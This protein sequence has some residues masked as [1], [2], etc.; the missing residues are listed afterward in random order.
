[1]TY[2]GGEDKTDAYRS[3]SGYDYAR[4]NGIRF[5]TPVLAAATGSAIF[6][7]K[8][9]SKG[10]GNII[11]ID[12]KNGYQ[13]WY[14]HLDDNDLIV[15]TEGTE[16]LVQKGQQVGKVGMTGNTNGPHIHFSVFKDGN[17]NGTFTDDYPYGLV[18]PLGWDGDY[19]DPWTE[20][21]NGNTHG[22]TSYNLF[23]ARLKP[24]I[25]S[26]PTS[27]AT[28]YMD[29]VQVDVPG[30]A[31]PVFVTI[32]SKYGPF[33][34][35]QGN[36]ESIMPS[37]FLTALDNL[38]NKITQFFQKIKISYDY[39][40]A[41]LYGIEEDSIRLNH[42]NEKSKAWEPLPTTL[43]KTNKIAV[44]Y[45]SHF[46]QFALMGEITDKISPTTEVVIDGDK[47]EQGWYKSSL[48]VTLLGKDNE[49]GVGVSET[50]YTT[51]GED[52]LEY[53]KALNFEEEGEYVITYK[54]IDNLYNVENQKTVTFH[55]DKTVPEAI[56]KYDLGRQEIVIVG[57][58]ASLAFFTEK[59]TGKNKQEIIISDKAGNTANFSVKDKE[60]GKNARITIDSMQ[61]NDN[62]PI[63]LGDNKFSVQYVVSASAVKAFNQT[64][65]VG[66][67]VKVKTKYSSDNNITEISTLDSN[68]IIQKEDMPGMKLL[69]LQTEN[70]TVNYSY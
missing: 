60:K 54:S 21:A 57:K 3:H 27:G 33:E 43:D 63:Y 48:S 65:Q 70:G 4:R 37:I 9:N 30:G 6:I 47:G 31:S 29:K 24:V 32:S 56:I 39:S 2:V 69:L 59:N 36:L 12:H 67:E 8:A 7:H 22:A 25:Q 51:N 62:S 35:S 58:D 40:D 50:L 68:G 18:D 66:E 16:V 42:Y 14:E 20:Y 49:G 1:M 23:T 28:L 44:A 13:T 55:I 38:N 10:A 34:S 41:E 52:W 15:K 45:T 46:S 11:K 5:H 19:T 53:T 17:N 26:V 64:W 61:Y